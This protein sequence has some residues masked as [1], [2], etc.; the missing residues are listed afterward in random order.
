M[1]FGV[2]TLNSWQKGI[3]VE[4]FKAESVILFLFF[5]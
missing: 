5:K 1:Q 2:K 4:Y 3:E